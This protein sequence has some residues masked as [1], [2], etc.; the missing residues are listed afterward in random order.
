MEQYIQQVDSTLN[1]IL[2]TYVK[3]PT[4]IKGIVHLLLIL[5]AARLAPDLP[6][7]VQEVFKNAYFKLFIFALILWSAQF[8]PSIS[9]LIAIGFMVT[10]NYINNQPLWEFMEN[11]DP[12][13]APIAPSKEV[14]INATSTILG[15]Q[16]AQ[17]P[18]VDSIAQM[19]DTVV[20]QP[21]IITTPDGGS[22]VLNPTVVVAPAIVTSPSGQEIIVKPEITMVPADAP[23]AAFSADAPPAP[24][25]AP[26]PAPA[27]P[28]EPQAEPAQCYPTRRYDMSKVGAFESVNYHTIS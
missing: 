1:K 15:E 12:A 17:P 22:A 6:K 20:I 18:A 26:E 3:K 19:Q 24:A 5:Y 16:T 28:K 25:P 8:S 27:Q 10:M 9:I 7:P 23:A 11:I 21:S 2:Q 13:T 14:A 4:I